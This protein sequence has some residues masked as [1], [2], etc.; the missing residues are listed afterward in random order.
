VIVSVK[1]PTL[2]EEGVTPEICGIGFSSVTPLL[3]S[4]EDFEVSAASIVIVF[5]DG[6]AVGA[7]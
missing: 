4:T 1:V 5:G 3:A 6:K 2:T 7:V